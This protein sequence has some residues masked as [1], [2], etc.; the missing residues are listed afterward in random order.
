MEAYCNFTDNELTKL[1]ERQDKAALAEV[2]LRHWQK[3]YDFARNKL[4]DDA[5][6]EDIVH[7]VFVRLTANMSNLHIE[8]SLKSYLF[9]AVRNTIIDHFNK[10]NNRQKYASSLMAYYNQGTYTTDDMIAEKEMKDRINKIVA[11]FPDKMREVYVMSREN[12]LSREEIAKATNTS[13]STVDTQL[14]RALNLIR[15]LTALLFL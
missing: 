14:N 4:H 1:L 8:T 11:S 7:D 6:A 15:K 5:G 3:L 10:D 9:Q 13:K 12:Y 2:Y